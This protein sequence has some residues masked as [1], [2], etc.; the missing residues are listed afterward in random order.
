MSCWRYNHWAKVVSGVTPHPGELRTKRIWV[1]G[2]YGR[3]KISR[4]TKYHWF[5]LLNRLGIGSCPFFF[6]CDKAPDFILAPSSTRFWS[7]RTSH[8]KQGQ[9]VVGFRLRSMTKTK[10]QIL[11]TI[12]MQ[13]IFVQFCSYDY[14]LYLYTWI[15]M[16]VLVAISNVCL[17]VF[18]YRQ[19][20]M[21]H[22]PSN[23]G[24]TTSPPWRPKSKG[25]TFQVEALNTDA[26]IVWELSF[27]VI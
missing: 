7:P 18:T 25:S 22:D 9:S 3:H 19:C 10:H 16:L 11:H 6:R 27:P 13:Y 20:M 23:D 14:V 4:T 21:H 8:S 5:H 12:K 26:L 17:F 15:W 1:V 24:F 2:G